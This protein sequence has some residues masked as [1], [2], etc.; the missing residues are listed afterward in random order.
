MRTTGILRRL[1]FGAM[2]VA[3]VI[4]VG[5]QSGCDND[6]IASP[7]AVP[8]PAPQPVVTSARFILLVEPTN[9]ESS[10]PLAGEVLIDGVSVWGDTMGEPGSDDI[11]WDYYGYSYVGVPF[12]V[13]EEIPSSLTPG[14]HTL[15]FHVTDQRRSPT[16]YTLTGRIDVTWSGNRVMR[17]ANWDGLAVRLQTGQAWSIPFEVPA[18]P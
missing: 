15:T 16:R 5:V 18:Q 13:N 11:W 10:Y 4:V 9:P 17:V 12:N 6:N 14:A 2:A 1:V 3:G 8:P 7:T